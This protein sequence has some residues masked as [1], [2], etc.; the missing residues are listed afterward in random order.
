MNQNKRYILMITV[1]ISVAVSFYSITQNFLNQVNDNR[2]NGAL[3][4]LVPALILFIPIIIILGTMAKREIKYRQTLAGGVKTVGFIK[5]VTQTGTYKMKQPEVKMEL[6]V[7]DDNGSK[8]PGEVITFVRPVELDFLKKG[9]P[10]PVIYKIND[11][12]EIAVDRKPDIMKL[13]DKIA[14]YKTQNNIE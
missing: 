12:K 1:V 8:F 10:V 6:E 13:K 3:P 5:K 4:L 7:L 14:D 11:K 2:V 9:E